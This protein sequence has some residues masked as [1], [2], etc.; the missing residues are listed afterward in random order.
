MRVAVSVPAGCYGGLGVGGSVAGSF[1]ITAGSGGRIIFQNN[2]ISVG[3]LATC[4]YYVALNEYLRDRIA[5][6]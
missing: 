4:K 1:V 5:L 2:P 3:Y 6:F